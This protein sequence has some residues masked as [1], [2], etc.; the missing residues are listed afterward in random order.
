MNDTQ[1]KGLFTDEGRVE[2][3]TGRAKEGTVIDPKA[4]KKN[5]PN[6]TQKAVANALDKK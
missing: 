3:N 5:E 2:K 4:A 1:L 6:K